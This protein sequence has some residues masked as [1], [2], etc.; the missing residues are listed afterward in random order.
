VTP[1][2]LRTVK[3]LLA[4]ALL[5]AIAG[6]GAGTALA[7]H[8]DPQKRIRAADQAKARAMLVR[9]SDLGPGAVAE[10]RNTPDT[11]LTCEGLDESDLTIT[12][13]AESP[14]WTQGV[15]FVAS[16]ANVYATVADA[17][18]SWT[19]GARGAGTRCLR[20]QLADEF[21][22]QGV[23]LESLRK[24][25]FPR[26]SER[27]VAYR[28]TLSGTVQGTTVRVVVD[29]V[30]LK[31][32]RAQAALYFGSAFVPAAKADEVA[33]ARVVARRMAGAMKPR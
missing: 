19:R 9:K 16:A 7:D 17:N 30:I 27:T 6:T 25:A 32:S 20:D 1:Y 3:R 31:H 26:V 33:L 24:V 22:T 21:A 14:T 28:I 15:G 10:P 2:H 12:G 4:F 23:A 8:F 5:L 18:A 11:H 13:E 29:L